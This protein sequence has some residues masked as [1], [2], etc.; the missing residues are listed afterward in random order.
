MSADAVGVVANTRARRNDAACRIT[1]AQDAGLRR[2]SSTTR[3]GRS[4][5]APCNAAAEFSPPQATHA[6]ARPS[7]AATSRASVVLPTPCAAAGLEGRRTSHSG[8]V[9]LAAEL[10]AREAST[11]AIQLAGGWKDA[12]MVVR[13]AASVSTRD[14][15]VSRFMRETKRRR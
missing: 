15:A 14:G 3:P 4:E 5:R 13:Y 12:G 2:S 7:A 11:H 9:G 10:T 6:H 8:H 1:G